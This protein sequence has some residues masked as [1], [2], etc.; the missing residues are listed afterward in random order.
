MPK[1]IQIIVGLG[2]WIAAAIACWWCMAGRGER[3]IV[4]P[5]MMPQLWKYVT[6]RPQVAEL[7]FDR[8]CIAQPGD[9][10]FMIKGA[11][12]V[13]QVGQVSNVVRTETGLT[14][15]AVFHSTAPQ[16]RADARLLFHQPPDSM[17]WV[18]RTMLPKEKR[19]QIAAELSSAFAK[20]QDEVVELLRPI[21]E[22]AFRE[23]L[24]VV[25]ADLPPAI[26]RRRE[27]L[28]K[29][30][31]KYQR[32][33]V[34]RELVPL[35]RSEIWPIVR[36]HAEPT[37]TEVGREIWE[38]ASVWRFAWRYAYDKMPLTEAK[39]L[40]KEWKRFVEEDA[41]P[42][43]E[44]HT[45]EFIKLQ[46]SILTDVAKNPRVRESVRHSLGKIAND[47]ELQ[48][49][50]WEIIREVIVDNPRLR[51]VFEKHRKS[52]RTQRAIQVTSQRLEPSV[53]RIGEM[54][55][56]TPDGG[57]TP[58]FARVLRNQILRKDRR[59]LVLEMDSGGEEALP[60]HEKL[61]VR[62]TRGS[63]DAP[64]PF[65]RDLRFNLQD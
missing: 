15:Y 58:E 5:H 4:Q 32:E 51:Q 16:L 2:I 40:E 12:S 44:E 63:S 24:A 14:G 42:V 36:Q 7:E 61:V 28:E 33:V 21:V 60:G 45:D 27:E 31:G 22:D 64:N 1:R 55:L 26:R 35:V 30:G 9:P 10:I 23:A 65:V 46:Q 49:I 13:H 25:E 59:W 50:T 48:R 17:E 56:G 29:L 43:L 37:A 6:V 11:N 62:V 54:L 34:E 47:P 52:E 39:L 20:H 38:R 8:D 41:M 3:S 57:V 18:L 53:R 19:Q